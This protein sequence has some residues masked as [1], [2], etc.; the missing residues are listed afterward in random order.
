M[1]RASRLPLVWRTSSAIHSRHCVSLSGNLD[2]IAS[3][4]SRRRS[5]RFASRSSRTSLACEAYRVGSFSSACSVRMIWSIRDSS[6]MSTSAS[7]SLRS[8][9][10]ESSSEDVSSSACAISVSLTRRTRI[11]VYR[12]AP[13]PR[14]VPA[15]RRETNMTRVGG[16]PTF[17]FPP[18][19]L[20]PNG[21]L[22][23]RRSVRPARAGRESVASPGRSCE[24][25]LVS[26]S[27][28]SSV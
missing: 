25:I 13:D 9:E 2:D 21:R 18:A 8:S 15:R 1:A 7:E 11:A 27:T 6:G 26:P 16:R 28:S 24:R 22:T 3:R 12:R 14:R 20:E 10:E 19:R 4:A 5:R 23:L 17:F